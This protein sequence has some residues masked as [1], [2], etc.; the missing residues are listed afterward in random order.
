MFNIYGSIGEG[1]MT[2]LN[3]SVLPESNIAHL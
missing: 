3:V 2:L 1:I